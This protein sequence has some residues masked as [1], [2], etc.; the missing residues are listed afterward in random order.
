MESILSN[1]GLIRLSVFIG[2]LVGM[3]VLEAMLPRRKRELG[4]GVRWTSNLGIVVI[5]TIVARLLIP[6]PPVAA[7]LWAAENGVG[8]LQGINFPMPLIVAG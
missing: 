2:I 1:E 8:V 4:R 5:D 7:A 3:M 6:I